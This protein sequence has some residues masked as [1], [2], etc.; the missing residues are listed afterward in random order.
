MTRDCPLQPKGMAWT[1]DLPQETLS[2]PNS[3][4]SALLVAQLPRDNQTSDS[5]PQLPVPA[6]TQPRVPPPKCLGLR[7]KRSRRALEESACP[8]CKRT[9]SGALEGP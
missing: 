5:S 9:H 1:L 4:C 8:L 3:H 6:Q 2:P 7:P